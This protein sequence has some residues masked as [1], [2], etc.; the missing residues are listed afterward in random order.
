MSNLKIELLE[1]YFKTIFN[2][3]Y[4]RFKLDSSNKML[5]ETFLVAL[6]LNAKT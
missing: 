6:E 3:C 4:W 1:F 2:I 5:R